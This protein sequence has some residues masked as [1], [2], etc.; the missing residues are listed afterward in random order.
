MKCFSQKRKKE[1]KKGETQ[2]LDVAV[3]SK[4]ILSERLD[5]AERFASGIYVLWD[6]HP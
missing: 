2:T 1:K 3:V 4:W 5:T 6:L